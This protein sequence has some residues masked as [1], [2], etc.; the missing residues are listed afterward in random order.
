[1]ILKL[2]AKLDQSGRILTVKMGWLP[3]SPNGIAVCQSDV[4]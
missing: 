3:P 2:T 4:V 1:M